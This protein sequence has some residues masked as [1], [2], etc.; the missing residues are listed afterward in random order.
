VS[1]NA[2]FFDEFPEKI[3]DAVLA[4]IHELG[5][6]TLNAETLAILLQRHANVLASALSGHE[7]GEGVPVEEWRRIAER[8]VEHFFIAAAPESAETQD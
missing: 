7:E 5:Y 2:A 8:M 6:I 1:A 3:A 4:K